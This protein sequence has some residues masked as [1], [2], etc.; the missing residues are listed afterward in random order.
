VKETTLSVT[1]TGRFPPKWRAKTETNTGRTSLTTT[2]KSNTGVNN[3]IPIA[4]YDDG[5]QAE[6]KAKELASNKECVCTLFN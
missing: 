3:V 6:R 5:W 2:L 4:M 1:N